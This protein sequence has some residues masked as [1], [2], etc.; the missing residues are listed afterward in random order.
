MFIRQTNR[1]STLKGGNSLNAVGHGRLPGGHGE[2]LTSANLSGQRVS[3]VSARPKLQ[4][5]QETPTTVLPSM[6]HV[7]FYLQFDVALFSHSASQETQPP[8]LFADSVN[9]SVTSR[10]LLLNCERKQPHFCTG[11]KIGL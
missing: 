4:V 8:E 6:F 1:S 7:K 3:R 2:V 10:E 5:P 9:R 11:A